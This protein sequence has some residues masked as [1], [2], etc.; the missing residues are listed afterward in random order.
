MFALKAFW[1]SE[2]GNFAITTAFA[3]LPI[4]IGLAGA[5]DLIGTSHDASQLQNSLDAAG[6]AIGTKFSPDMAAG[7]VQPP[8]LPF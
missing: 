4:M 7:G 8:G 1:S 3:M 2:R 6:L 5:V